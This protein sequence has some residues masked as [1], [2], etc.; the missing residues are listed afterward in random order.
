ME[1]HLGDSTFVSAGGSPYLIEDLLFVLQG[2]RLSAEVDAVA[3]QIVVRR[4][5][6]SGKEA[7]EYPPRRAGNGGFKA[8]S[9]HSDH[10]YARQ[11]VARSGRIPQRLAR[12]RAWSK[13][14]QI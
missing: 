6:R 5:R 8:S 2:K 4:Q 1:W 14:Q 12:L 13:R 7:P 11:Q 10:F 9:E 3:N